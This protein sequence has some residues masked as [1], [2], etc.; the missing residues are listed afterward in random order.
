MFDVP[1]ILSNGKLE[2]EIKKCGRQQG[3]CDY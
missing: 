1:A 3:R 2:L